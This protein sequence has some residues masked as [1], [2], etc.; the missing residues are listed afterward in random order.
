MCEVKLL[1]SQ[2]L[3]PFFGWDNETYTKV[4]KAIQAKLD[5]SLQ[6][7][8]QSSISPLRIRKFENYEFVEDQKNRCS[9]LFSCFHI[10]DLRCV[11]QS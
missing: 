6:K 11:M 4:M 7:L 2:H 1:T 10:H 3:W 8:L 5:G 9:A